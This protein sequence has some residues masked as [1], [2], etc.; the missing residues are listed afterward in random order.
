MDAPPDD[1][2]GAD[3]QARKPSMP[4]MAERGVEMALNTM[5]NGDAGE[6]KRF[7]DSVM[8][9]A[10]PLAFGTY[11]QQVHRALFSHGAF[12]EAPKSDAALAV[13]YI[14]AE[15]GANACERIAYYD[16]AQFCKGLCA[17]LG[18]TVLHRRLTSLAQLPRAIG[19][20]LL[21]YQPSDLH[22]N[23]FC[24]RQWMRVALFAPN[25]LDI[26]SWCDTS[27]TTMLQTPEMADIIWPLAEDQCIIGQQN[28][29]A[30]AVGRNRLVLGASSQ[31]DPTAPVVARMAERSRPREFLAFY[32]FF[33]HRM[34]M[35]RGNG[36]SLYAH[37][38]ETQALFEPCVA[39][40]FGASEPQTL[41]MMAR[42]PHNTL[43][44]LAT[45]AQE[46]AN[47]L[48]APAHTADTL[49]ASMYARTYDFMSV[50][51]SL[52]HCSCAMFEHHKT[53]RLE[54]TYAPVVREPIDAFVAELAADA[55]VLQLDA[56]RKRVPELAAAP[57]AA[58]RY[59][60]WL[61]PPNVSQ[62]VVSWSI[63]L[64]MRML[65]AL[66]ADSPRRAARASWPHYV[67]LHHR[68]GP[69]VVARYE[70][71]HML[72]INMLTHA[73][74]Q[75][76]TKTTSA[77]PLLVRMYMLNYAHTSQHE[78]HVMATELARNSFIQVLAHWLRVR[79]ETPITS[80]GVPGPAHADAFDFLASIH[81]LINVLWPDGPGGDALG[82]DRLTALREALT[83]RDPHWLAHGPLIELAAAADAALGRGDPDTVLTLAMA[84][85]FGAHEYATQID[86]MRAGRPRAAPRLSRLPTGELPL[87][88]TEE[89]WDAFVRLLPYDHPF[90]AHTPVPAMADTRTLALNLALYRTVVRLAE[91]RPEHRDLC[92][93]VLLAVRTAAPPLTPAKYSTKMY[94]QLHGAQDVRAEY[95]AAWLSAAQEARGLPRP[96]QALYVQ[97]SDA[98]MADVMPLLGVVRALESLVCDCATGGG[99]RQSQASQQDAVVSATLSTFMR[100]QG[101]GSSPP[102]YNA[103]VATYYDS[104]SRTERVVTFDD[105]LSLVELALSNAV[106]N[107]YAESMRTARRTFGA[108]SRRPV[109]IAT[110][111]VCSLVENFEHAVLDDAAAARQCLERV[112]QLKQ[113]HHQPDVMRDKIKA[114]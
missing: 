71:I 5:F 25:T 54:A 63:T 83:L 82:Y 46:M 16:A 108:A 89:N 33:F 42:L 106:E 13:L 24:L 28:S 98:S 31:F 105:G 114:L 74:R 52:M 91:A 100:R 14:G 36:T 99:G 38:D 112:L 43:V 45:I 17:V 76:I 59:G 97:R 95:D 7:L 103:P 2:V 47:F 79:H 53:R 107:G 69:F 49:V 29:D 6:L 22:S 27:T 48:A 39:M 10:R 15:Y 81:R 111:V 50:Y 96:S 1:T 77:F 21:F 18:G 92:A 67:G 75:R 11:Q 109:H 110:N 23:S 104:D 56:L 51:I 102:V 40:L 65:D 37:L 73:L 94:R 4:W 101:A 8:R 113:H 87:A 72:Q 60:A 30:L 20:A 44:N 90:I 66:Y 9:L 32:V 57:A 62:H 41:A 12:V 84:A 55:Q 86:R 58:Q 70:M 85:Q 93:R 64:Y 68:R 78:I 3:V 61:L 34:A 19:V 35:L 88:V 80:A 26:D